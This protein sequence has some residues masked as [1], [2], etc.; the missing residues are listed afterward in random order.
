MIVLGVMDL[1]LTLNSER[2]ADLTENSSSDD[3]RDMEKWDR[4]NRMSLMIMKRAIPEA[5][6]GT[7]SEHVTTA[8]S[9][10]EQI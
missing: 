8:K 10:L 9:F 2:P 4:F 6:I 1:D 7:M 5:F 3:K